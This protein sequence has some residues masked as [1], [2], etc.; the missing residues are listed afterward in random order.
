MQQKVGEFAHP[1]P[2]FG[3]FTEV[4]QDFV[5]IE[6]DVVRRLQECVEPRGHARGRGEERAKESHLGIVQPAGFRHRTK[7]I[8]GIDRVCER[9]KECSEVFRAAVQGAGLELVAK[10][11]HTRSNA[12]TAIKAPEGFGEKEI[13]QVLRIMFDKHAV[14]AAG[15]PGAPDLAGVYAQLAVFSHNMH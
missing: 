13:L 8:E 9:H 14:E 2:L 6:R 15:I 11:V 7:R 12:V 3:C 5:V 10:D 4:D 1:H